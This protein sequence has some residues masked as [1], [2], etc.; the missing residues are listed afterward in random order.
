[1]LGAGPISRQFELRREAELRGEAGG[2]GEAAKA[3]AVVEAS[4]EARLAMQAAREQQAAAR[5]QQA[6]L[7]GWQRKGRANAA[8]TRA[9]AHGGFGAKW[10]VR[11][12][13]G[14]GAALTHAEKDGGDA[15]CGEGATAREQ[16][17]V[18]STATAAAQPQVGESGPR[19]PASDFA[20]ACSVQPGR[21]QP[22][23]EAHSAEAG[24][25]GSRGG[26]ESVG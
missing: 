25:G 19:P 2:D 26:P 18:A 5:E 3:K 11:R 21:P 22:Q 20:G 15:V 13:R 24:D 17:G 6:Q 8:S 16:L 23:P 14:A 9:A 12:R 1:M 7:P 10:D 4:F